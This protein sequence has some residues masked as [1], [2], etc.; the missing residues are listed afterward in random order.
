MQYQH[1]LLLYLSGLMLTLTEGQKTTQIY[2]SAKNKI[3][4]TKWSKATTWNGKYRGMWKCNLFVYD[5]LQ[6]VGATTP[7]KWGMQIL[8]NEWADPNSASVKGTGCYKTVSYSS[9]QKGDIV[10]FKRNGSSGHVGIM[11]TNG[12]FISALRYKVDSLDV[13]GFRSGDSFIVST[14][15]WRYTC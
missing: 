3:N 4:S 1:L 10:A 7:K 13:D 2:E 8:A 5:V 14:T 11:S 6:E 9:K 15:V 12:N